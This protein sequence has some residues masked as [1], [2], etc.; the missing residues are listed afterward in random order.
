[1]QCYGEGFSEEKAPPRIILRFLL[2][3]VIAYP[4][5]LPV[6]R[7]FFAEMLL[8]GAK[9]NLEWKS[10]TDTIGYLYTVESARR[11]HQANQSIKV[12]KINKNKGLG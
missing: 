11:Q 3:T 10:G 7:L 4:A 12:R 2:D 9:R 5:I 8:K 1:M 6:E